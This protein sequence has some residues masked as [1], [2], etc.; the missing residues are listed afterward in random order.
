MLNDTSGMISGSFTLD[1]G[2]LLP[3]L[4]NRASSNIQEYKSSS[5]GPV[6]VVNQ[7]QSTFAPTQRSSDSPIRLNETS[8]RKLQD[9]STTQYKMDDYLRKT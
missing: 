4:R 1:N 8:E 7:T 2:P 6:H 9:A 3:D 5:K